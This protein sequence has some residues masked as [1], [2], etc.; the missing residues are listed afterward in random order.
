MSYP[1]IKP[2]LNSIN[3]KSGLLLS[4]FILFFFFVSCPYAFLNGHNVPD[5][6]F[7]LFTT[8]HFR[9]IY[10]AGLD[11]LANHAA[12]VAE[13]ALPTLKR[14]ILLNPKAE[15]PQITLVITD[16]DHEAN[17]SSTPFGH[18]IEIFAYP[19]V[20]KTTGTLGWI[21]RV[22]VHELAHQISYIALRRGLG[23]YG[24]LWRF[25]F[26][27]AW[28]MEGVAQFEAEEWDKNREFLLKSAYNQGLFL[29]RPRLYGFSGLSVIESRL[30]YEQGHAL[31]RFMAERHGR[32]IGGKILNNIGLFNPGFNSAVRRMTG[33]TENNWILAFRLSLE[34]QY[35]KRDADNRLPT[36]ADELTAPIA[37]LMDQVYCMRP[38]ENGFFCTGIERNDVWESGLFFYRRGGGFKRIDGPDIDGAFDYNEENGLLYY[39]RLVRTPSGAWRYRLFKAAVGG[40]IT[41]LNDQEGEEPCLLPE[42]RLAFVRFH[43][44]FSSLYVGDRD[45]R[46]VQRFAL[47]DSVI[48]VFRPVYSSGRLY[49]SVVEISGERKAASIGL[50]GEDYRIEAEKKGV[51]IRYPDRNK[52]GYLAY[53]SNEKGPFN[54]YVRYPEDSSVHPVTADPYGVFMSRF[55]RAG[56]SVVA[57]SLSEAKQRIGLAC[58]AVSMQD[59]RHGETWNMEVP[60]KKI[61]GRDQKDINEASETLS[62][63]DNLSGKPYSSLGEMRPIIFYPY[64]RGGLFP[65]KP[66]VK[67]HLT[68]PI[69]RHYFI[70]GIDNEIRNGEA[71][72]EIDYLNTCLEPTVSLHLSRYFDIYDSVDSDYHLIERES[73]ELFSLSA[74]F[75]FPIDL[76]LNLRNK[77]TV[78]VSAAAITHREYDSVAA[79]Q[80]VWLF[81][82][83]EERNM[84]IGAAFGETRSYPGNLLHPLDAYAV[85]TGITMALP[86][87]GSDYDYRYAHLLLQ[88]S[89]EIG[90]SYQT[91]FGRC[92]AVSQ[93]G[94]A[95]NA[96]IHLLTTSDVPR[97]QEERADI[98]VTKA[99]ALTGEY[100][101]PITRDIG[102]SLLG[103]YFEQMTV[104]PF[105]DW[106]L[107]QKD[108]GRNDADV[109]SARSVGVQLRQRILV[110]GMEMNIGCYFAYDPS[111]KTNAFLLNGGT[112]F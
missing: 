4:G 106:L 11:S 56:D 9:V 31:Y 103:F 101:L 112:G 39:S 45:G 43:Q 14:D 24:E 19:I 62:G 89:V 44:S 21:D 33:R 96:G 97:G 15:I 38:A 105:I 80:S 92:R 61:T 28:F 108:N 109:Q 7:R 99:L 86:A 32:D 63:R 77:Q 65:V 16:I 54:V 85:Q 55:N 2:T 78:Y 82:V 74:G 6:E 93:F 110:L 104:G 60:W 18:T 25:L 53:V 8:R 79:T 30:V 70:A 58:Y 1:S 98:Y 34:K 59:D 69:G 111:K 68:D 91:L 36:Y 102:L 90:K 20:Q 42:D 100:R 57:I 107:Y 48:Q 50:K 49:F 41:P 22:V 81:P 23:L 46:N 64:F 84:T 27:P 83:M 75:F 88:K 52:A 66:G 17:G 3:K 37:S 40:P 26:I 76:S 47:P 95:G 67:L 72:F 10:Q 29:E 51:D 71:E 73:D 87:F 5:T 94:P 35:P 12:Q 13:A